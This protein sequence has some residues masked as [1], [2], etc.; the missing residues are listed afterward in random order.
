MRF[1]EFIGMILLMAHAKAA[2]CSYHNSNAVWLRVG[3]GGV[4][5]PIVSNEKSGGV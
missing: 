2:I 3:A 5:I 4:G 1:H